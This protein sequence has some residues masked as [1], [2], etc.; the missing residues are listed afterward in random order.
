MRPYETVA[1]AA[2]ERLAPFLNQLAVRARLVRGGG[3][4]PRDDNVLRIAGEARAAALELRLVGHA[5]TAVSKADRAGELITTVWVEPTALQLVYAERW[6]PADPEYAGRWDLAS[7]LCSGLVARGVPADQI[8]LL[9]LPQR[10]QPAGVRPDHRPRPLIA[11]CVGGRVMVVL[12]TT[13][14]A[15][16]FPPASPTRC[17]TWIRPSTHGNARLG[18][19]RWETQAASCATSPPDHRTPQPGRCWTTG[20]TSA[21]YSHRARPAPARFRRCGRAPVPNR[22]RAEASSRPRGEPRPCTGKCPHRRRETST[23]PLQHGREA[24]TQTRGGTR[25]PQSTPG[26]PAAQARV[27]RW[28]R[29]LAVNVGIGATIAGLDLAAYTAASAITGQPGV[30]LLF[31]CVLGA[32]MCLAALHPASRRAHRRLVRALARRRVGRLLLTITSAPRPRAAARHR[33]QPR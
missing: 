27:G 9:G 30:G 24:V 18:R 17:T 1:V 19:R 33:R 25:R 15:R 21:L 8:G 3:V 32:G 22:P 11:D 5:S 12:S 20:M 23:N 6:L 2:D 7:E 16:A 13:D 4:N 14:A 29:L 31:N 28:L 10:V 26:Q